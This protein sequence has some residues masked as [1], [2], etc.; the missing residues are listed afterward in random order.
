MHMHTSP[1]RVRRALLSPCL[2]LV[3]GAR[4]PKGVAKRCG[5]LYPVVCA[6]TATPSATHPQ[7]DSGAGRAPHGAVGGLRYPDISAAVR[8][9]RAFKEVRVLGER[10]LEIQPLAGKHVIGHDFTY[11]SVWFYTSGA[12]AGRAGVLRR[13]HLRRWDQGDPAVRREA[14]R[15]EH[16][17]R[18]PNIGGGAPLSLEGVTRTNPTGTGLAS[19]ETYPSWQ[20]RA[21]RGSRKTNTILYTTGIQCIINSRY[22]YAGD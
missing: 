2:G 22:R 11:R 4:C 10:P 13:E 16:R 17:R 7:L 20:M 9:V 14:L 6:P 21:V 1:H 8:A 19:C 15:G 3:L 18:G 5:R 12:Q